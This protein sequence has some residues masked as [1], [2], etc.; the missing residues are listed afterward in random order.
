MT[1]DSVRE[2]T[3]RSRQA[4]SFEELTAL[5]QALATHEWSA[6]VPGDRATCYVSMANEPGTQATIAA[7]QRAGISVAVPIM[8]PGRT[9]AWGWHTDDMPTNNFGVREPDIDNSIDVSHFAAM[10]IPAQRAGLDGSRLGRGAGY[11]DRALESVPRHSAGGPLRITIV[12]DDE[13]DDS[14][15]HDPHDQQV[16]VIVTPTRVIRLT[17]DQ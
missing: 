12:F 15:P 13:V 4:R 16:D 8:Q 10:L 9:L 14:V 3:A 5:E 11:Y 6:L 17:K 1:K 2:T 7:L